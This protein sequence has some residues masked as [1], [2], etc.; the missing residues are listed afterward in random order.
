MTSMDLAKL[1]ENKEEKSKKNK[2]KSQLKLAA[3]PA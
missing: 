3:I 1:P 2:A